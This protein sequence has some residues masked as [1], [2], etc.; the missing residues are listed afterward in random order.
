MRAW[1]VILWGSMA[2]DPVAP[3]GSSLRPGAAAGPGGE[4][5]AGPAG[6]KPAPAA[7]GQGDPLDGEAVPIDPDQSRLHWRLGGEGAPSGEAAGLK[8]VLV[9]AQGQ[10]S[11]VRFTV[12]TD[13]LDGSDPVRAAE[14]AGQMGA[15]AQPTIFVDVMGWGPEQ[16]WDGVVRP[17]EATL[18]LGERAAQQVLEGQ[19]ST[20][21]GGRTVRLAGTIDPADWGL[22]GR[23]DPQAQVWVELSAVFAWTPAPAGAPEEITP[24]PP[25]SARPRPGRS[26]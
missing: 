19:L 6:P 21:E 26:R 20:V 8:G 17:M 24:T 3:G 7:G 1:A 5:A 25:K 9:L 18:R 11:G 14:I 13:Q 15:G 2:C 22:G 23:L 10:P 4:H 16:P 12:P